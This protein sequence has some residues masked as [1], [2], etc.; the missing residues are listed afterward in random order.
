MQVS[1]ASPA[2]E[3]PES[4]LTAALQAAP[5]GP[6]DFLTLLVA[7]LRHQDPLNP[8]DGREMV[9]Q[10]AQLQHLSVVQQI[11]HSLDL[12]AAQPAGLVHLLGKEVWWQAP[13]GTL[14]HGRVDRV[15]QAADGWQ[16]RVG[17]QR[18]GWRDIRAI[19]G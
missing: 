3:R 7:E 9:T 18:V 14:Q 19:A 2:R 4:G 10:L 16:V 8:M 15:E 12:L 11:Q 5:L 13:D 1:M 17:E 6:E